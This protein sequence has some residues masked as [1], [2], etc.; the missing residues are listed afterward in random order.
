MPDFTNKFP[1]GTRNNGVGCRVVT[2][3]S[4]KFV[5]NLLDEQLHLGKIP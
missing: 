3:Y 4:N 1:V 2:A 5:E